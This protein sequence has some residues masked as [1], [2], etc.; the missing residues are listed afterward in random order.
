VAL[1]A[2]RP[3]GA[4]HLLVFVPTSDRHG[5]KLKGPSWTRPTLETLGRPF[6]GATAYPK[7]KGVWRDDGADGK[8]VFDDTTIVFSYIAKEDL[9][10]SSLG[11]LKAFL[12]RLG[13]DTHQGEVGMVLDGRYIGINVFD[14]A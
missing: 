14:E 13:R 2:R 1:G 9:T 3:L 11:E 5:R 12:H 6:R 8:L 7:G 10:P 4:P